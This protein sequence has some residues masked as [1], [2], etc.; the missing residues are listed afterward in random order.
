VTEKNIQHMHHDTFRHFHF[1]PDPSLIH[2]ETL[3]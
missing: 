1:R 2:Y 3:R